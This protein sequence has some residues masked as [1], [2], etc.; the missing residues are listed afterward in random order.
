MNEKE[1]RH[2]SKT[3]MLEIMLDQESEVSALKEQ[4][5][6]LN[7]MVSERSI[8]IQ[9]AGSIAE[10]SLIINKV[11]EA[12]QQAADQYLDNVKTV[13]EKQS[14]VCRQI[15]SEAEEKAAGLVMEAEKQCAQREQQEKD[16]TDALWVL[17]QKKLDDYYEA[18][19]DL[20]G[21][22]AGD[23]SRRISAEQLREQRRSEQQ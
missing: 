17:L 20:D 7:F 8:S 19:P 23:G 9:K 12:A 10:A 2:L 22:H 3:E 21:A 15:Q 18:K 4:I 14:M 1:L 16:Y 5:R 13:S 11:M 6:E